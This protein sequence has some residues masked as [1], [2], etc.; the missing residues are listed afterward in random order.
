MEL[1]T[2]TSLGNMVA[3]IAI[4]AGS[5]IAYAQSLDPH[6]LYKERCAKCHTIHA[7]DFIHESLIR[8]GGKIIG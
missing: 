2:R 3:L 6:R 7:G 1:R 8:S 5:C 4:L